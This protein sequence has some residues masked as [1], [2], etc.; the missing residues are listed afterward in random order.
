MS[1]RLPASL[2]YAAHGWHSFPLGPNK[3]PLGNCST[4]KDKRDCSGQDNCVCAVDTCHGFYAATVDTDRIRRWFTE[5]PHWMLGIR[6]GACSG[7]VALDIDIHAGGDKSIRELQRKVGKLPQTVMQNSGSGSSVHMLFA[8][9]GHHVPPSAG[10]LG[11]GLDVRGD[12]SYIVGAPTL[13]PKTGRPYTWQ[14][15]PF[16]RLAPWPAAL[17]ELVQPSAAPARRT[18][19]SS[20]VG[21]TVSTDLGVFT[22]TGDPA[23]RVEAVL[24]RVLDATDGSRNSLLHWAACRLGEMVTLGEVDEASA[25]DAL[26][27]AGRHIGLEHG[28]LVGGG[29]AGTIHSGLAAGRRAV[30]A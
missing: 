23:R 29:N 8:H 3:Q 19:A 20:G 14:G 10:K 17:D 24:R 18:A 21:R 15:S 2:A 12:G 1:A 28:E 9:P 27:T 26:Y 22:P 4:C 6:A 16:G 25:I 30:M 5:H 13:H 7:F 11:D